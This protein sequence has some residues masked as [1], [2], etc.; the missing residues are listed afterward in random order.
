MS[1]VLALAG[2]TGPRGT[3]MPVPRPL[4]RDIQSFHASSDDME[5]SVSAEAVEHPETIT[6]HQAL[7]LA[8]MKNPELA[9]YSWHIR[10]AEAR[11]LQAGML[12][13]PEMAIEVEEFGGSGE[14][15]GFDA[16]RMS[17]VLSQVIE[18]GGKRASRRNTATLETALAAW[19]YEIKRL[20]ILTE[21]T[22]RFI[23]VLESQQTLALAESELAVAN[24]VHHA[25][26]ERVKAG[27]DSPLES[28]K[29]TSELASSKLSVIQTT[30][31]LAENRHLL[32]A[33]WGSKRAVFDKA[34][35]SWP[36]MPGEIP[37]YENIEQRLHQNPTI[38]HALMELRLAEAGLAAE[39]TARIPDLELATGVERS[40]EED[41]QTFIAGMGVQMPV[42]DRNKGRIKEARAAVEKAR[43]N[44]RATEIALHAELR[45][46]YETLAAA[47]HATLILSNE[48]LPAAQEAFSA[49]EE[50]YRAGKFSYLDVLDAQ[51][52]LFEAKSTSLEIRAEYHKSLAKL[53]RLTGENLSTIEMEKGD[54]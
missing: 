37:H 12:P 44:K 48:V 42:F 43:Q 39:K 40:E 17:I 23:D 21:T 33:M 19:E 5:N 15:Q 35:G 16:A 30:R 31:N 8:L 53:E 32:A 18:L 27:K 22:Q 14:S 6:L 26:S 10:A 50:G 28:I 24:N 1:A 7:A 4:G 49:A 13:N 46:A 34:A 20:D 9:V 45:A 52:T 41:G 51:R 54:K 2:C 25:V 47:K 36:E 3:Q 38:E 11:I 29:S